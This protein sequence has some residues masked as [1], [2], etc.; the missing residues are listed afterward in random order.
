MRDLY[1]STGGARALPIDLLLGA[2]LSLPRKTLDRLVERAIAQLDEL[3][4]DPDLELN[5]D[6]HDGSNAED[7]VLHFYHYAGKQG[8]GF[9][10]SDPA[11]TARTKNGRKPT[12][13]TAIWQ[14]APR[15]LQ[16]QPVA[17]RSQAAAFGVS[18]GSTRALPCPPA[19]GRIGGCR[20]TGARSRR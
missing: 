19:T 11:R 14:P 5:G 16:P 8:P 10:I 4:G 1:V 3:D 17:R 15:L 18:T 2:I 9:L 12:T 20:S 7:E 6:E 13:S